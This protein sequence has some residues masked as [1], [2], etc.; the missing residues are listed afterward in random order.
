MN[1]RS[2]FSVSAA[3]TATIAGLSACSSSSDAG[4]GAS[5]SASSGGAAGGTI[6]VITVDLANPYWQTEADAAKAAITEA[7]YTPEVNAH[8]ND[9]DKQNQLIDSAITNK[10][11]AIIL[12]PAG[13]DQSVAAVE[14]A[15]AAGIP[16]FLVN[17]EI[18]K[19]GVAKVQIVSNNAQGAT[20]GAE[21]WAE[22][23]GGKGEY[24]ELFGAPTDNNAQV[25]SDGYAGVLSGYPDLKK[26]GQETA[27]WDR[28]TGKTKMEGLLAAHPNLTGVISG[29][30]EMALGAIQ[31][32]EAAGKMAQI[33]VL[34]FDGSPDA[35]QAVKDGK[36]VATVL[37]PIVT[38][39][40][41]A[42]ADAAKFIETGEAPATEKVSIDCV[43][44][45]KD[46][47]D[48][49]TAPFTLSA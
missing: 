22:A 10:V 39:T 34:G 49:V 4:S 19:Q 26:L 21:A 35:V 1:R 24:V 33:K 3:V 48:K 41:Q 16:C 44:I 8:G 29:N 38:G 27:N 25:R 2:F 45:N 12:D 15:L 20:I 17:A 7:G 31:A 30:D 28:A 9:P 32:I 40:Q 42:V 36:L 43:L 47:A 37:Q 5:S 14:K 13:A 11:K 23:M 18:S 6:S 46:N